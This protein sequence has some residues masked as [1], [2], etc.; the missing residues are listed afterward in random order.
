MSRKTYEAK[1]LSGAS[2]IR[3]HGYVHDTEHG[4]DFQH[5]GSG[6]DLM[7][8][9]SDLELTFLASDAEPEKTPFIRIDVLVQGETVDTTVHFLKKGNQT[10][11]I[12]RDRDDKFS[13]SV[14]KRSEA[15]M[16]KV[17]LKSVVTAGALLELSRED[18][19]MFIEFIGDSTTC[20]YGN[21]GALETPFSTAY[22]D[23]LN[24]YAVLA[25]QRLNA[26][27]AIICYSGIG[28][29]KSFY[30]SKT[31]PSVYDKVDFDAS[32]QR[33]MSYD[34]DVII[35]NIGTNDNTYMTHLIDTSRAYEQTRFKET[36][37]AFID[38][39]LTTHQHATVVAVTQEQRQPHVEQVIKDAVGD[40]HNPRVKHI[41]LSAIQPEEGIGSQYHPSLLTHQKWAKELSDELIRLNIMRTIR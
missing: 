15:L 2:L 22:E 31:M 8:Q 17:A 3:W 4:V 5:T 32:D 11:K 28:M 29:Y 34:P 25:S 10:I 36:Y 14:R 7:V 12:N 13:V 33:K 37:E 23:G 41:S 6:F 21:L 38:M 16:S 27:Y 35:L 18:P 24:T 20:G 26:R 30:A 19:C 1:A 9:G 40:I 39:L